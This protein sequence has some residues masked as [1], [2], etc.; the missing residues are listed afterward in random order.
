LSAGETNRI[1][2]A[3]ILAALH[4]A[5]VRT[6]CLCPG[7]RNAPLI[8]AAD[9][10]RGAFDVVSFFE[11]RSAGFFALGRCRRDNAPVAV[12]TTSGTAAAEL[13]PPV[14]EAAHSGLPLIVVTADRPRRLRGT[15][16][17]Q[18][19]DQVPL[20]A[21]ARTTVLDLD[22]PGQLGSLPALAGPLH[23]NVC[24]D[25]PL[26]GEPL[27]VHFDAAPSGPA[28]PTSWM[29]ENEARAVC[30]DFFSR[31]RRP[32]VLV[33]S[34][35][36][37]DACTLAP[38]LASLDSPLYLEA[39]SQL[40]G[41]PALQKTSLHG[42]ERILLAPECRSACDGVL[43]LGGVP[44]PRYWRELEECGHPVLHVS[45][46]DLPGLARPGPVVPLDRFLPICRT[47]APSG[48]GHEALLALDRAAEKFVRESLAA[49]PRSEAAHVLALDELLP[50]EAR[51]FLGN[52]L[53]IRE[54]DLVARRRTDG[55][56]FFAN[57]GVN[58]IDGLISSALGL[59]DSARPTAAIIGDLSALYDL[60]G[61][62]PAEQMPEASLTIAVVN[63]GGGAIFDRMF[64][65]QAFRNAHGLNF[66]GWADMFGWDFAA[67]S[68][69]G[70]PWPL[71]RRR[72]VE[73]RPDAA[74]T[75]RWSDAL[76]AWWHA[77]GQS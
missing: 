21:A 12:V 32:L 74:A 18:T 17:P 14:L 35:C 26:G 8:L 51:V 24:F 72:L 64:K 13:L 29:T 1:L 9:A 70:D 49:E 16:A 46:V 50:D 75:S 4:A 15:G 69:A 41:H 33:S 63:N 48:G 27:A 73:V 76:A 34:L 28:D 52:S 38:W 68:V 55:R 45:R 66:R 59:A 36:P 77:A 23:L 71:G 2:A 31:V 3:E 11:E 53:P 43:R 65:H 6:L 54:W 47:Y 19:I 39:V 58:G 22:A 62:W 40:R 30:D 25:E 67:V 61:L 60:P 10:A 37:D 57:R 20:F 56:T 42:G 44:T 7:G 5:G